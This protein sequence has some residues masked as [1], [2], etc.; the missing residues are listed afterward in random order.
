MIINNAIMA[1]K[2]AQNFGSIMEDLINFAFETGWDFIVDKCYAGCSTACIYAGRGNVIK[3]QFFVSRPQNDSFEIGVKR[4]LQDDV[5]DDTVSAEDVEKD[6]SQLAAYLADWY[7]ETEC[8]SA[9][10]KKGF[11]QR[12]K[13]RLAHTNFHVYLI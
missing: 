1:E 2:A 12:T 11:Q 10:L 8:D 5:P 13:T 7:G 9:S 6:S 3:R 4:F